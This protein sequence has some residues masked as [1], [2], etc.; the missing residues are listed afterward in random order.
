MNDDYMKPDMA[1]IYWEFIKAMK[2]TKEYD[3]WFKAVVES[4]GDGKS[5]QD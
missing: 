5:E 3:L 2:M 1:K 4:E